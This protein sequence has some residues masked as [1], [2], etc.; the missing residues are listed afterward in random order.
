M[1]YPG[2]FYDQDVAQSMVTEIPGSYPDNG[3]GRRVR[4]ARGGAMNVGRGR[5]PYY[6]PSPQI[7]P[8]GYVP[9]D[10]SSAPMPPVC[11]D[12]DG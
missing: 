6:P 3:G 2:S 9:S 7:P 8:D 5:I 12:N 4:R 11:L 10:W 1:A